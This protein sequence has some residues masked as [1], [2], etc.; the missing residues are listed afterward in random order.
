MKCDRVTL[1]Q[2]GWVT[3]TESRWVKRIV[4]QLARQRG[5]PASE[6]RH[7]SRERGYDHRRTAIGLAGPVADNSPQIQGNR[8]YSAFTVPARPARFFRE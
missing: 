6:R 3:R 1:S 4:Y 5:K 2:T 8:L 7:A